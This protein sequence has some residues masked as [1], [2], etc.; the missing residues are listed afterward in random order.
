MR[1]DEL[2]HFYTAK[3]VALMPGH[4]L[5]GKTMVIAPHADDETLGCGGT[6][7][8]LVQAGIEVH[9]V[10]VSDGS[11]SHPNSSKYNEA[12][13]AVLRQNEAIAAAAILGV[14]ENC[15]SFMK[16]KDGAVPHYGDRGFD[17]A[18]AGITKI[19]SGV[20]PLNVFL[21]FENDPH[22]DHIA[23]WQIT[24]E[25]LKKMDETIEL[26]QYFIWFWERGQQQKDLSFLQWYKSDISNVIDKKNAAIAAHASQVTNLIDDD[27]KGFTLSGEVLCHFNKSTELFAKRN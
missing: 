10:F 7:S 3:A 23:C 20:K 17:E 2:Q 13:R 8:L 6:I 15:C 27:P 25:A 21:P 9:I 22:P 4:N 5:T 26:Y 19:I 18:V 12:A 16:L 1:S 24:T 14:P 11:M